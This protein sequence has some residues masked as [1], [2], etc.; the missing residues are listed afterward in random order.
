M[1]VFSL[2]SL[3]RLLRIRLETLMEYSRTADGMYSPFVEEEGGRRRT[4]DRP[5][6]ALR[7][8]QRH[9]YDIFLRNHGYSEF[10][11]GGVSGLSVA[12]AVKPHAGRPL[13]VK[14]DVRNFY[15]SISDKS[16]FD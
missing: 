1:K 10:A 15:P 16:I 6:L 9:I 14:V 7:K 11:Y 3:A 13:V 8:L 2:R 4:I 12:D 5:V